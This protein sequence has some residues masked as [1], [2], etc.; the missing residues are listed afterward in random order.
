MNVQIALYT[1]VQNFA[2]GKDV[3][4]VTKVYV[5]QISFT[6]IATKGALNLH[7]TVKSKALWLD[8]AGINDLEQG[9]NVIIYDGLKDGK[10]GVDGAIAASEKQLGLNETIIQ[11]LTASPFTTQVGVTG[12]LKNL[13]QSTTPEAPIYVI[14]TGD[15]VDVEIVY[16]V[17]TA[18]PKLPGV[19]S[20]GVTHGSVIE[21][22][23]YKKA[24]L[25][26]STG[27]ENGKAYIIKLYL[28]MNSV[29]FDAAVTPWATP[30]EVESDLPAN[31][32]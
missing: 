25:G 6:G 26:A 7:N 2:A 16:D 29:K 23:I 15:E 21:N 30:V 11:K 18:D 32:N 5:R 31:Q 20:D 27:F 8:Y 1:D 13:F 24:I 14:P 12:T 9:E 3:A 4:G 10:E 19:L 28:G 22:R 17:E